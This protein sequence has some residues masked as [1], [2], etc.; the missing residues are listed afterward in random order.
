MLTKKHAKE[1]QKVKKVLS[2]LPTATSQLFFF[3]N[4]ATGWLPWITQTG[5][6]LLNL[7]QFCIETSQLPVFICESLIEQAEVRS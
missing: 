7:V 5:V 6:D 3:N 1:C 2:V 4:G